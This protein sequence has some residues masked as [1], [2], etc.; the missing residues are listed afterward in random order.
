MSAQDEKIKSGIFPGEGIIVE[1]G[2]IATL[3]S[4]H[5]IRFDHNDRGACLGNI[6]ADTIGKV[7]YRDADQGMI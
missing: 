5:E 4:S 1:A 6:I 3:R 2:R 7:V